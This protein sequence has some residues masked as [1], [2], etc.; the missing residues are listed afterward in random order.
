MEVVA[1]HADEMVRRFMA[2]VDLDFTAGL[3][4]FQHF[5]EAA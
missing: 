2:V 4:F 5:G 3:C 1:Q